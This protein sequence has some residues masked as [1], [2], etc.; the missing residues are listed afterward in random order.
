MFTERL[1][2]VSAVLGKQFMETAFDFPAASDLLENSSCLSINKNNPNFALTY[3]WVPCSVYCRL[4]RLGKTLS[5]LYS[6]WCVCPT[7]ITYISVCI[8]SPSRLISLQ[9]HFSLPVNLAPLV[10]LSR[11]D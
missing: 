3:M 4:Q 9:L 8:L 10:L 2:F 6:I 1:V 7:Q 11:E 5:L